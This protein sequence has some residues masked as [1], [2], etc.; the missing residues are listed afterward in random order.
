M[1]IGR[2]PD[3]PIV[4]TARGARCRIGAKRDFRFIGTDGFYG[5]PVIGR[6]PF[7]TGPGMLCSYAR[8]IHAFIKLSLE[9]QNDLLVVSVDG[10]IHKL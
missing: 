6:R 3:G 2:R 10:G 4:W 9:I 5:S 7:V 1:N 8:V